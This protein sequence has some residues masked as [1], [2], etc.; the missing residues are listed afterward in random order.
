[1]SDQAYEDLALA[2]DRLPNG[3]P[4]TASG[5]EIRILEKIFAP[6]EA[7]L[8]ARLTGRYETIAEIAARAG[9]AEN[10]I[11]RKLVTLAQRGLVW[12]EKSDGRAR[13]RLAPFVVGIYEASLH[14]LDHE[15]AHLVE[16]Y[17]R[18]GGA[19]GIMGYEPA[20]HRVVPAR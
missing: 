3:Y 7:A 2:M 6:D 15:L 9:L 8:A 5:I 17:F 1:M 13:F 4:R 20:L 19:K 10:E 18:E 16:D 11:N 12:F 14:L